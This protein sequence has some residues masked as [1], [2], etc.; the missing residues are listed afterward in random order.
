MR[1]ARTVSNVIRMTFGGGGAAAP[2]IALPAKQ[3]AHSKR[4]IRYIEYEKFI[5]VEAA[6][7]QQADRPLMA[8][9]ATPMHLLRTCGRRCVAFKPLQQ[10]PRLRRERRRGESLE[11]GL[12]FADCLGLA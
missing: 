5:I 12:E 11:V 9:S 2:A 8:G 6:R 1:S 10:I 3:R 4:R 7:L